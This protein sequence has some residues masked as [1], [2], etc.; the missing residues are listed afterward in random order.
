MPDATPIAA[1]DH[2][3]PDLAPAL[4]SGPTPLAYSVIEAARAFV[5]P[6]SPP[7]IRHAIAD[8]ALASHRLG[9]GARILRT[10]LETWVRTLPPYRRAPRKRKETP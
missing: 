1:D 10:D 4:P 3:T 7:Q 6:I 2:A 5:P 9:N 8:G